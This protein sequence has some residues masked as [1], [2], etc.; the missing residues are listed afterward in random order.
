M[1]R[2]RANGHAF[3]TA[4]P[5]HEAGYVLSLMLCVCLYVMLSDSEHFVLCSFQKCTFRIFVLVCTSTSLCMLVYTSVHMFASLYLNLHIVEC[6][7]IDRSCHSVIWEVE[8]KQHK[9]FSQQS[10]MKHTHT[11]KWNE[12]FNIIYKPDYQHCVFGNVKRV[13]LWLTQ[14]L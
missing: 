5:F 12:Y 1:K 3:M 8:E 7:V 9:C 14:I 6:W 4:C 11:L 10:C 2:G 13:V